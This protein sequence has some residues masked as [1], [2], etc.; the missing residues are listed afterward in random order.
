MENKEYG[1]RAYKDSVF[2][3]L[4]AKDITARENFILLY[5]GRK[6]YIL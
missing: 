5:N 3:D 1:K 2:V 6:N 4:F